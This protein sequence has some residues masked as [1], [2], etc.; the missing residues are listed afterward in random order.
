MTTY[1]VVTS[2]LFRCIKEEARQHA[3]AE[4]CPPAHCPLHRVVWHRIV[5]DEAHTIKHMTTD[6]AKAVSVLRGDRRWCLR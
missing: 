4:T 5:L 6:Q 3:S 1:S 2:E